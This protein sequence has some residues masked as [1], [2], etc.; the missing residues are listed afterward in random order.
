[1]ATRVTGANDSGFVLVRQED[2]YGTLA[3]G[4]SVSAALN[5]KV[6]GNSLADQRESVARDVITGYGPTAMRQLRKG[7]GGG[8][9]FEGS[10]DGLG[11]FFKAFMGAVDMLGPGSSP[12]PNDS[13]FIPAAIQP[14]LEIRD[15][16]AAEIFQYT[17]V[18]V[19]GLTL[20]YTDGAPLEVAFDLLAKTEVDLADGSGSTSTGVGT[21]PIL[22][23]E[24]V[25]ATFCGADL[26]THLHS[27]TVTCSNNMESGKWPLG[28]DGRGE[29]HRTKMSVEIE[30]T[31][32]WDDW[33]LLQATTPTG[34][35]QDFRDGTMSPTVLNLKWDNGGAG[36]AE[37]EFELY[38]P[39]VMMT[40]NSPARTDAGPQEVT[41]AFTALAA[42]ITGSNI[43]STSSGDF[44]NVTGAPVVFHMLHN[45]DSDG[46]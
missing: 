25:T 12:T 26:S 5:Y 40:G 8:L 2:S 28:V 36:D 46:Y 10:Y 37:R 22:Q 7:A 11:R 24:L 13:L 19:D 35:Y 1:M 41:L 15:V 3:G 16:V 30:I 23:S 17:G 14:S 29:P 39:N 42:D 18:K 38:C 6:G 43:S 21:A 45:E 27:L 32:Y 31:A 20:S 34:L 33:F 4:E 44:S 9:T